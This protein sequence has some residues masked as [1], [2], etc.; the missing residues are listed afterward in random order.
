MTDSHLSTG[1]THARFLLGLLTVE[2]RG[3]S[4]TDPSAS[5][6][7]LASSDWWP[8]RCF[9]WGDR[10]AGAAAVRRTAGAHAGSQLFGVSA[11]DPFALAAVALLLGLVGLAAA[12]VPA[13]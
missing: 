11:A 13:R 8:K 12:L 1:V 9:P 5:I 4:Q 10:V 2:W 3:C 6:L 7:G